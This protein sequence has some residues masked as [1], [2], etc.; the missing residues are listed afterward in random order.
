VVNRRLQLFVHQKTSFFTDKLL[1]PSISGFF[2]AYPQND[3]FYRFAL[4]FSLFAA[5]SSFFFIN[6]LDERV[7]IPPLV[8]RFA[9]RNLPKFPSM[10]TRN[11]G[12]AKILFP[13]FSQTGI[14]SPQ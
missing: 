2:I 5:F 8:R 7:Q 3:H 12:G 9:D 11:E 6:F 10:V 1:P 14:C 13:F 4:I